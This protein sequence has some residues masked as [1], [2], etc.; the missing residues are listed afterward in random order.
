MQCLIAAWSGLEQRVVDKAINEWHGLLH[1]CVRADRQR[2]E[3]LHWA[4]NFSVWMILLFNFAKTSCL[5]RSQIVACL[6]DLQGTAA[7]GKARFGRLSDVKVS[8]QNSS[9]TCLLKIIKFGWHLANLLHTVKGPLFKTQ[10]KHR[11]VD[12]NFYKV[13]YQHSKQVWWV[14]MQ[15]F[16]ANFLGY[17]A[18]EN[19]WNSITFSQVF[20]KVKRVTFFETV[21]TLCPHHAVHAWKMPPHCLVKCTHFSSFSFFSQASSTNPRYRRSVLLRHGLNFS[22]AWWTMQLISSENDWK[23]VSVQKV[24]LWTFAATL[25][26]WHSICH[27]SQPVFFRATNTNAQPAFI[28]ATNDWRNATYL[29]SDEKV[30]HFNDFIR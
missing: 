4:A 16:V 6:V 22:T 30:V 11:Y 23:R 20:A 13:R 25:L 5:A 1:A 8:L 21:Y 26:V 28:R 19:Y 17:A 9:G 24:S 10:C 15:T 12:Q 18:T 3:H 7:T 14:N 27:T 29:Q 2:F